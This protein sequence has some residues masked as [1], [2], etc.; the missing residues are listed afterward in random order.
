MLDEQVPGK[1]GGKQSC[2]DESCGMWSWGGGSGHLDKQHCLF[3]LVFHLDNLGSILLQGRSEDH[4]VD[5]ICF[6]EISDFT[7]PVHNLEFG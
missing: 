2:T 6:P 5:F 4:S 7:R 1:D 3:T